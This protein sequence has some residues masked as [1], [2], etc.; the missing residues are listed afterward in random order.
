MD[1]SNREKR[2]MLKI[3]YQQNRNSTA[4]SAI[5]FQEFPERQQPHRTLFGLLDKNLVEY[6][7]FEK[8][9]AKYGTRITDEEINRVIEQVK[10][11]M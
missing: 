4:A 10:L 2:D 7:S 1:Y 6:G 8:P 5:Y 9:R 3:Y 11:R